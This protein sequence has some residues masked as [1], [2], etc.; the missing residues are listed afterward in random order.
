M[1]RKGAYKR[2]NVRV[3]E[4]PMFIRYIHT[5]FFQKGVVELSMTIGKLFFL[6][7]RKFSLSCPVWG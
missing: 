6:R 5:V 2:V 3:G 4:C 7:S 1:M